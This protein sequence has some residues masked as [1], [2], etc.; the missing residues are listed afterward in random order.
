MYAEYL[1]A[2]HGKLD[3]SVKRVLEVYVPTFSVTALLGVTAWITYDAVSILVRGHQAGDNVDVTFMFAFAAGNFVV[4]LISS[5]LFYLKG[6]AALVVEDEDHL[7]TFSL[8]RRTIDWHKRSFLPNLNMISALTH[9]GS[10]TMRTISVFVAATISTAAH[11]DSDL[12]DAWAAVI[13][14]CTILLAIV[15]LCKEIYKA[16]NNLHDDT[17]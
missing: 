5:F 13:V 3:D 1:K 10:D 17:A 16:A 11:L 14:T 8:D 9:I 4:D 6:E 2:K 12:C 7:R 15:P